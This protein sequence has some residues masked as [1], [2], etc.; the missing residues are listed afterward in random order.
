MPAAYGNSPVRFPPVPNAKFRPQ[1]FEPGQR[2]LRHLRVRKRFR[3][4]FDLK[5]LV[6]YLEG[7]KLARVIGLF[8]FPR[9]N[10]FPVARVEVEFYAV[11]LGHRRFDDIGV[12]AAAATLRRAQRGGREGI[13]HG[14]F[15]FAFGGVQRYARQG[16]LSFWRWRRVFRPLR[17]VSLPNRCICGSFPLFQTGSAYGSVE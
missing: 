17:T 7:V 13:F 14:F 10:D 4:G 1:L 5:F 9:G 12:V 11:E 8:G 2:Y 15:P 6:A 3:M 16:F